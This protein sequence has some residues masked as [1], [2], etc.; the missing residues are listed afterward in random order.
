M[1]RIVTSEVALADLPSAFDGYMEGT[2]T[3]RAVVRIGG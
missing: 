1:E 2:V 3:G